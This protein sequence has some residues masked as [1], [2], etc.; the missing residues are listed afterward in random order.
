MKINF[1]DIQPFLLPFLV[2]ILIF[3]FSF[4]FLKPEFNAVL[5]I[6]RKL[7]NDKKTL[8]NL[9]NKLNSLQGL[10][11]A[12]LTD[13]ANLSLD[14]LPAEKDVPRN[15]FTIKK[16]AY[17]NGLTITNINIAE[18]GEISTPSA[19]QQLNKNEI[20][21]SLA[22]SVAINGNIEQ[23]KNFIAQLELT[24]PLMKANNVFMT[25][26]MGSSAETIIN[27]QAFFL[28]FPQSIG[29][30][31]QPLSIITSE[32]EKVFTKIS[33][34]TSFKDEENIPDLPVGKENLF[35]P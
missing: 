15:L 35:T 14:V 13:K 22:I 10:A 12:E 18:V 27:L 30:T 6:N 21:P 34:F 4:V 25:H 7:I 23:I 33:E 24:S 19:K 17:N 9:T 2:I 1:K 3:T 32:E 26:K 20:L 28:P 8:A 31:E 29:K 16:L 5:G 11:K